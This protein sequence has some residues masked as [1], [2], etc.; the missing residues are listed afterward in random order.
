VREDIAREL[1]LVNPQF[2]VT[3]FDR[4]N[5][6]YTCRQL[7][8]ETVK[9]EELLS[10]IRANA[11][12][13]IIYCSTRKTV[14]RLTGIL[15]QRLRGR[16]ICAYH[17]G[18][19]QAARTSNQERFM[20]TP[21]AVV[22]ATNAFGMGINKPDTR[23]V[24]HYNL[25]GTVEA[26]YQEAGRAGRDG[27]PA[28]CVLFFSTADRRTQEFFIN[29][30]GENN[31]ALNQR[32][33]RELQEHAQRKLQS[34]L[35]FVRSRRCRRRAI[36]DYFGDTSDVDMCNCDNCLRGGAVALPQAKAAIS[37]ETTL[38]VRTLVAGIARTQMRGPYG[39]GVIADVLRGSRTA[40]LERLDLHQLSVFGKLKQYSQQELIAMLHRLIEAGLARQHAVDPSGLRPVITLTV[41]GIAVMT[42]ESPVPPLLHDLGA[43]SSADVLPPPRGRAR[44]TSSNEELDAESSVRFERLRAARAAIARKKELPAFVILHDRVLRDIARQAP[45]DL[46]ALSQIRGMGPAKLSAYGD[47]LLRALNAS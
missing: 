41:S 17:A 29:N 46:D 31:P 28:E 34:L 14:D 45:R 33:V 27:A 23:F 9:D 11:G 36:L 5:L 1:S 26:Y 44:S 22:V 21:G 4:P 38:L 12:S 10:L 35:E 42:E 20:Q 13:G 47:T 40:K 3:G 7:E 2:H 15:A 30:L 6:S 24:I 18:M 43:R 25:P 16:T 32:A 19:E 37:P 39:A 8:K